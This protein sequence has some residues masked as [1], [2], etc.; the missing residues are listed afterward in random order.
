MLFCAVCCLILS[1]VLTFG[2]LRLDDVKDKVGQERIAELDTL[3]KISIDE[4]ID[5][6]IRLKAL[7][8]LIR[9]NDPRGQIWPKFIYRKDVSSGQVIEI[10]CLLRDYRYRDTKDDLLDVLNDTKFIPGIRVLAA[11]VLAAWGDK[12]VLKPI[13][14]MIERTV[15][16][17]GLLERLLDALAELKDPSTEQFLL[18]I[19]T[20]EAY[21]GRERVAAAGALVKLGNKKAIDFVFSVYPLSGGEA[22][23]YP[24]DRLTHIIGLIGGDRAIEA[25]SR[26]ARGRLLPHETVVVI[27]V[28]RQI[29]DHRFIPPLFDV[30]EDSRNHE[31]HVRIAAT[32]ALLEQVERMSTGDRSRLASLIRKIIN[33]IILDYPHFA[34]YI[35]HLKKQVHAKGLKID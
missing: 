33:D 1:C 30:A 23:V 35:D 8:K 19:M 31:I 21:S 27:K 13:M 32:E 22:E 2:S 12:R 4:R 20:N 34:E 3:A 28:M 17:A 5:I 25:L 18:S 10:L 14:D 9:A 7:M 15:L 6:K 16:D 29:R 24:F 11:Q 26:A